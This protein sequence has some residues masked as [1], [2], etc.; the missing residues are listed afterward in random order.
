MLSFAG[1]KD[2]MNAVNRIRRGRDVRRNIAV[3]GVSYPDALDRIAELMN[4]VSARPEYPGKSDVTECR[5]ELCR[6]MFSVIADDV[7]ELRKR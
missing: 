7:K 6:L 5:R 4:R 3:D 1:G 2:Q